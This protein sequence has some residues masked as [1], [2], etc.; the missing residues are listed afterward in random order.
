MT[1]PR[2]LT[3]SVGPPA[4]INEFHNPADGFHQVEV[5]F[6]CTVTSGALSDDWRDPEGIVTERRFVT[7]DELSGLRHKPDSLT[8]AAWGEGIRYDPLEVIVR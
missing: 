3:V 7:R 6:R 4:L 8:S 1:T 2:V 5:F